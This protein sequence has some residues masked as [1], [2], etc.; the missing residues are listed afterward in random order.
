MKKDINIKCPD[1]GGDVIYYHHSD[2]YKGIKG[3]VTHI[4]CAKKCQGW[5]VI[6]EI[7]HVKNLYMKKDK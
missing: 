6:Q 3:P 4:V 5:K 7:D 1:C 2:E